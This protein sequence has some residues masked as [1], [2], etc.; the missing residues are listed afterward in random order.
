MIHRIH[1]MVRKL[2]II[3][4][5]PF[6]TGF[7]G[8][9]SEEVLTSDDAR[10]VINEMWPARHKTFMLGLQLNIPA[11]ELERIYSKYS[12]MDDRLFHIIIAFLRQT[13]P[14]PTWRVIGDAL[15][16]PIVNLPALAMEVEV[17]HLPG[18]LPIFGGMYLYHSVLVTFSFNICR[19]LCW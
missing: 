18:T 15:R 12:N 16:S 4:I 19:Q 8:P 14:R 13:E 5:C 11:H 10:S 1:K 9:A 2:C 7:P 6:F 3:L 17:A